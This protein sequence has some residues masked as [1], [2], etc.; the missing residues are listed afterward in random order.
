MN[1]NQ[2][3]KYQ[4]KRKRDDNLESLSEFESLPG[5]GKRTK[6][7]D[8]DKSTSSFEIEGESYQDASTISPKIATNSP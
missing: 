8:L 5:L 3:T 7:D 4:G 6:I 1:I 2:L